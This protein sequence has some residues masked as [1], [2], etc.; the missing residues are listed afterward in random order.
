MADAVIVKPGVPGNINPPPNIFPKK[1]LNVTG[2][3]FKSV[4]QEV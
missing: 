3:N 2:V 1:S 4:S